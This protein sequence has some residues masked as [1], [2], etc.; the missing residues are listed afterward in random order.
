MRN[1]LMAGTAAGLFLA[2][3]A[4]N[5]Y[6][7]PQNSPYATMVPPGAVDGYSTMAPDDGYY[8]GD[9]APVEGR[10][11]YVDPY[12]ADDGYDGGGYVTQYPA[13]LG[14]GFYYGG[15]HGHFHGGHFGGHM[16]MR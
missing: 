3:G 10:S 12:Y 15:G 14:G 16:R 4:V 6:A 13:P 7:V 9:S 1:I 5:A 8:Y 2:L 11:A